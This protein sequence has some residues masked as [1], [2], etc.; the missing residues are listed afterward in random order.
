M[1][2]IDEVIKVREIEMC[3]RIKLELLP[4]IVVFIQM[5]RYH[6]IEF[7]GHKIAKMLAETIESWRPIF[8][9]IK[10]P[11]QCLD[12]AFNT[13]N[14]DGLMVSPSQ[15]KDSIRYESILHLTEYIND[16]KRP[17]LSTRED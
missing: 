15:I 5:L 13:L 4:K 8:V 2:L 9:E 17:K 11:F 10:L 1:E 14:R 3:N 7:R 6:Q 16:E 12:E